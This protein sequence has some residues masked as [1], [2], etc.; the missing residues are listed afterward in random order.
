MCLRPGADF[1]VWHNPFHESGGF[2]SGGPRAFAVPAADIDFVWQH[3]FD[4]HWIGE[5]G[6]KLGAAVVLRRH[7]GIVLPVA[8]VFLGVRY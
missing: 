1:Y 2:F 4:R 7:E 3:C 8:G 6:F 5:S